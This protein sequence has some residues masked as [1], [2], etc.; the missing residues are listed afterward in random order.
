MATH[1]IIPLETLL[2]IPKGITVFLQRVANYRR[3]Y[4]S[5]K[6]KS[7][8][9]PTLSLIISLTT[10]IVITAF[11]YVNGN[12]GQAPRYEVNEYGQTMGWEYVQYL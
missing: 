2:K 4:T 8:I 12:Q 3:R 10:G 11:G 5:M 9:P 7:I 6:K 1:S